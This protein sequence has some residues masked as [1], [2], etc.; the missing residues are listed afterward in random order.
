MPVSFTLSE[1]KAIVTDVFSD[2]LK[3]DQGV[4]NVDFTLVPG[5]QPLGFSAASYGTFLNDVAN[6]VNQRTA[7]ESWTQPPGFAGRHLYQSLSNAI[8]DI[9]L[10]IK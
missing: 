2:R 4:Q 5:L 8:D 9:A 7:P 3:D 10:Q 6:D 1:K